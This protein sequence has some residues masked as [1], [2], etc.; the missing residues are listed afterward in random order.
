[1]PF[2]LIIFDCDGT[3]VDSEVIHNQSISDLLTGMGHSRFDL[4]YAL[5]HFVG[6]GM[7]EVFRHLEAEIGSS[8]PARFLPDYV[9]MVE[10]RM[11]SSLKAI[12]GVHEVL[13]G[14]PE[15]IK[16]CVASNGEMSNVTT[17][18]RVTGL[19]PYFPS[20][21]IFTKD[22]VARAKPAPDL[23]LHAAAKTGV[24]PSRAVVI[25]DSVTGVRAGKAADM[26]VI[27]LT[28]ASHDKKSHDAALRAAGAD[29]VVDRFVDIA[30]LVNL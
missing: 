19:E 30:N 13:A 24:H 21:L 11:E 6:K 25:E 4:E 26:V 20:A 29:H 16:K 28:A 15:K 7:E 5:A 27:G 22:M 2:D 3:L 23:F 14:L 12:D 18:I 8:L 10:Q 1:M 17:A 9:R